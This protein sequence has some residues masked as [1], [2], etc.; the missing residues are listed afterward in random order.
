M[1]FTHST[2]LACAKFL[3]VFQRLSCGLYMIYLSCLLKVFFIVSEA[4]TFALQTLLCFIAWERLLPDC[5]LSPCRSEAAG[6]AQPPPCSLRCRNSMRQD[7][8][9]VRLSTVTLTVHERRD[10]TVVLVS[11]SQHRQTS[12]VEAHFWLVLQLYTLQTE[13]IS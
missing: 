10:I 4:L 2:C 6:T 5:I 13:F 12:L 11:A 1:G 8:Q 3:L 9:T 7:R